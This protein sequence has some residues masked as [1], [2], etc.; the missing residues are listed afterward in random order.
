[1]IFMLQGPLDQFFHMGQPS[2]NP[3]GS[4]KQTHRKGS[5]TDQSC[6]GS[7]SLTVSRQ[8]G[9]RKL[10]GWRGRPDT[11]PTFGG[12]EWAGQGRYIFGGRVL[13]KLLFSI[14]MKTVMHY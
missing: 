4:A 9:R 12:G 10:G 8:P 3:S 1:M 7:V 13:I 14:V 5:K 6:L 11:L 2:L